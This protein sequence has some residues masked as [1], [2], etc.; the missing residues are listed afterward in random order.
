M[1][2]GSTSQSSDQRA[3]T[4]LH[5]SACRWHQGRNAFS[6]PARIDETVSAQGFH[7]VEWPDL[8]HAVV[9]LAVRRAGG[10]GRTGQ[11]LLPHPWRRDRSLAR[12]RAALGDLQWLRRSL[13]HSTVIARLDAPHRRP[14]ADRR[15]LPAASLGKAAYSQPDGDADGLPAPRLDPGRRPSPQGYRRLSALDARK[16]TLTH[17]HSGAAHRG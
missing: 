8:W 17:R 12:L 11:P 5:N 3:P 10:P 9:D 15:G 13:A 2:R 14:P 6:E 4:S 1:S 16:L 7:M